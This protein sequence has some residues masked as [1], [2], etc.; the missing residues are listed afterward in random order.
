MEISKE[1]LNELQTI[2]PALAAIEKMN[3]FQIPDGYFTGLDK[4]ICTIV[5]LHQDERNKD[6]DVPSGY[7]DELSSKI[8]SKI[9]SAESDNAQEETRIIS[10]ALY[11]LKN[12]N[13]FTIPEN[14]F[15][16]LSNKISD[17]LNNKKAKVISISV[18]RKWWKYAAAAVV[19]GAITVGSLQIFNNKS[20]P[21]NDNQFA[22]IITNTPDYVQ[23]SS[24]Y[25]TPDQLDS[26]IASLTDDEIASYLEKHGSILD[27][28]SLAK[29]IDTT[30]L[31]STDDY[32]IDENTLNNFLN[33]IDAQSPNKNTQ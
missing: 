5:F 7:F 24:K 30:E 10:P 15:E 16:N 18:G 29:D 11:Y 26:G 22:G 20:A 6:I 9:K 17:K 32:L 23:L 21:A 4:R 2:S 19:A 8:L 31:P 14:Y 28:G 12:E 25:K 33:T 27:E 3:V 1:I 13:V